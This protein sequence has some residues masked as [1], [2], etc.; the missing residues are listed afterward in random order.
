[1]RQQ[2]AGHVHV[3]RCA[4]D[5]CA[6]SKLR[7][8]AHCTHALRRN[9]KPAWAGPARALATGHAQ[10]MGQHTH[11]GP[12]R[13]SAPAALACSSAWHTWRGA[14]TQPCSATHPDNQLGAASASNGTASAAR[15]KRQPLPVSPRAHTHTHTHTHTHLCAL[16]CGRGWRGRGWCG[17]GWRGRGC[18]CCLVPAHPP[19][20]RYAA[21][22]CCESSLNIAGA[23]E[24]LERPERAV[25]IP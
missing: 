17:S 19:R 3:T 11:L 18:C 22:N 25:S 21:D 2:S 16:D 13:A 23:I 24:R 4:Q 15:Q 12:G 6:A 10:R 5:R 8:G 20:A 9:S 7:G 14:V 1:V